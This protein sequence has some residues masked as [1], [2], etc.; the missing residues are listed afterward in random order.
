MTI[1]LDGIPVCL[2]SPPGFVG[3]HSALELDAHG[4]VF[5]K[6]RQAFGKA[7]VFKGVALEGMQLITLADFR[8]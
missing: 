2:P 5:Y 3:L 6:A 4:Q 8:N 7:S 1:L